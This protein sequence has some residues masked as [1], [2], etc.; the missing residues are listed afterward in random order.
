MKKKVNKNVKKRSFNHYMSCLFGIGII[1]FIL[2]RISMITYYDL[3]LDSKGICTIA[4][5]YKY[6]NIRYSRIK[7]YYEFN[8]NNKWYRGHAT[9]LSNENLKNKILHDTITII[10]L[11][12]NPQIN[13]AKNAVENDLFVRGSNKLIDLLR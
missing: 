5:I 1:T 10:Y 11:P 4:E 6:K 2:V 3:L 12:S 13:R 8:V 9:S 7:G